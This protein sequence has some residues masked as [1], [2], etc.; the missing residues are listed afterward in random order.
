MII[1]VVIAIGGALI[2]GFTTQ[3]ISIWFT[4]SA[5]INVGL[6]NAHVELRWQLIQFFVT[7]I[8]LLLIGRPMMKKFM[9][10][11]KPLNTADS[12]IGKNG[13]VIEN[14]PH[15][16]RV[17]VNGISWKAESSEKLNLGDQIKVTALNGVTL[18]VK[19]I[20]KGL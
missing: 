15:Q 18:S 6:Y 5:L 16:L 19:K 11:F 12:I 17:K 1:W 10:Q 7:G 8:A 20:E 3:L 13:F 2:E 9:P 4:I 14:Q